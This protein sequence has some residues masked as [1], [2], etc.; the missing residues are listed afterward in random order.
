MAHTVRELTPGPDGLTFALAARADVAAR[1][2]A[3]P[4]RLAV[5]RFDAWCSGRWSPGRAGASVAE[6]ALALGARLHDDTDALRARVRRALADGRVLALRDGRTD[7]GAAARPHDEGE[8]PPPVVEARREDIRVVTV[9]DETWRPL[10]GIKLSIAPL[11]EGPTAKE[12][13]AE[14]AAELRGLRPGTCH[15]RAVFEG[16]T[17]DTCYEVVGVDAGPAPAAS[18]GDEPGDDARRFAVA[19]RRHKVATGETLASVAEAYGMTWKQ[20]AR[21]NFGSTAPRDVNRGLR[22]QVGCR[23]KTADRANY[24]FTDDDAPGILFIPEAW[25]RA[26]LST[27]RTHTIRLRVPRVE[28]TRQFIF[29]L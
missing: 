8:A 20:L 9:E 23:E 21:F 19:L 2:R 3:L 18:E 26:G 1:A 25:D 28:R 13:D 29:S 16:A 5:A 10:S 27:D 24:V 22:H 17:L 11:G 6:L 4:I 14:G 12:T 15:V 7:A